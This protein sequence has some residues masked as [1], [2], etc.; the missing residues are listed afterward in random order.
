M[1]ITA[2]VAGVV[3]AIHVEPGDRVDAGDE[4]VL[5]ESMK[6]L[7]PLVA[8]TNGTVTVVSVRPGELV[9]PGQLL[10]VLT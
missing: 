5:L 3:S 9:Q 10:A 1:Q 6:M 4:V 8:P 2:H 7:L